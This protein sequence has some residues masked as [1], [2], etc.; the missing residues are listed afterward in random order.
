MP[1]PPQVTP[2]VPS[3]LEGV[4]LPPGLAVAP[5]SAT[6]P[7]RRLGHRSDA[8]TQGLGSPGDTWG[9]AREQKEDLGVKASLLW[10]NRS[11]TVLGLEKAF[12][13]HKSRGSTLKTRLAPRAGGPSDRLRAV[14]GGPALRG[15]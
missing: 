12:S 6:P 10:R 11:E 13:A 8:Q 7:L 14:G 2:R 3:L 9:A 4:H 5:P 1:P 15:Q